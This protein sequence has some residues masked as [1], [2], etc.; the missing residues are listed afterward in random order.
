M[1]QYGDKPSSGTACI[2][3]KESGLDDRSHPF[4]NWLDEHGFHHWGRHGHYL[5]VDWVFI[6]LNSMI[7]APGMPGIS[8]AESIRHHAICADEFKT[9]WAIFEK[10]EGLELLVMTQEEQAQRDLTKIHYLTDINM[11]RAIRK[12][13]GHLYEYDAFGDTWSEID[14]SDETVQSPQAMAA[15]HEVSA[16]ELALVIAELRQSIPP[17]TLDTFEQGVFEALKRSLNHS[18]PACSDDKIH[19]IISDDYDVVEGSYRIA[20]EHWKAGK[21]GVPNVFQQEIN[22]AENTLYMLNMQ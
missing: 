9:I 16:D 10:Y 11:T 19:Q 22:S 21:I 12:Q 6:N 7:Y 14:H 20:L 2:L 13:Y 15:W 8:I 3:V 17:M 1:E 5:G 18:G 4:W